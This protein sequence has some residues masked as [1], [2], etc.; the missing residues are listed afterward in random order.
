M[1]ELSR[2]TGLASV[3]EFENP[4]YKSWSP[5]PK[6][7]SGV[8]IVLC[9]PSLFLSHRPVVR[10]TGFSDLVGMLDLTSARNCQYWSILSDLIF[11]WWK[12]TWGCQLT[13][14]WTWPS[15]VPRWPRQP[16]AS[17]L[18]SEI[19]WSTGVEK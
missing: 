18:I 10:P 11:S 14:G 1:E 9:D 16:T 3:H 13:A 19:V 15:G 17:W 12:R 6:L 4:L 2:S 8:R 5:L 7:F